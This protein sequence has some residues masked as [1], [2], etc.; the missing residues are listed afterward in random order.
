MDDDEDR[1]LDCAGKP[2]LLQQWQA[3][4]LTGFLWAS[5]GVCTLHTAN[6]A[7][8]AREIRESETLIKMSD[9]SISNCQCFTHSRVNNTPATGDAMGKICLVTGATSGIGQAAAL[10]LALQG[11]TVV[12]VGRDE[13]KCTAAVNSIVQRTGNVHID[14]LVADLASQQEVRRLAQE[15][16]QRYDKLD[17]LINNAGTNRL[18]RQLSPDGIE[19]V[20]ATNHLS[21]FLL[22]HLLLDRLKQSA[23]SR[24]VVVSSYYHRQARL[25]FERLQA[26]GLN[27]YPLSKLANLLFTYELA[28]RLEGSGV[29]VNALNP[30]LV[31]THIGLDIPGLASVVMRLMN[32]FAGI[33]VEEG[34]K[35][36]IYLA[37]SPEVEG[38]SGKYF[39]KCQPVASSPIS[40]DRA[41]AERL[42]RISEELTGTVMDG[43]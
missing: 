26:G 3:T 6:G 11:A 13:A 1:V 31:R 20:F 39:Q 41:A 17:V 24:I 28:R 35:T 9:L 30:G 33:S 19:L 37:T 5:A 42:W 8:A 12:I 2:A 34:A 27:A 23:P 25:D 21:H 10:G 36:S 22:S 32:H 18:V 4:A 40:Y 43:K 15:Y 14:Y 29:T 38:V 7:D 16:L